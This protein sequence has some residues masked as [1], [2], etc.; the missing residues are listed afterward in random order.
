MGRIKKN[1]KISVLD[2]VDW[3][4]TVNAYGYTIITAHKKIKEKQV[5]FS[6]TDK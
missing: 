1:L 6:R 3:L 4:I 2:V 5:A